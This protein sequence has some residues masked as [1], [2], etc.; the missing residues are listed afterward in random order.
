[1]LLRWLLIFSHLLGDVP[2]GLKN[3][4][5]NSGVNA[6]IQSIFYFKSMR[7]RVFE[8]KGQNNLVS[9]LVNFMQRMNTCATPCEESLEE[10]MLLVEEQGWDRNWQQS[11]EESRKFFRQKLTEQDKRFSTFYEETFAGK[12]VSSSRQLRKF[13]KYKLEGDKSMQNIRT[14]REVPKVLQ[15]Q[16]K[17]EFPFSELY[18]P[19]SMKIIPYDNPQA[20]VDFVLLF[21]VA[22]AGDMYYVYLKDDPFTPD[23]TWFE[24]DGIH[25]SIRTLEEVLQ[26]SKLYAEIVFYADKSQ[27]HTLFGK[28]FISRRM[29]QYI[30]VLMIVGGTGICVCVMF[31]VFSR[32]YDQKKVGPQDKSSKD[33]TEHIPML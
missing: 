32:R 23:G 26:A 21:V 7:R 31:I 12:Y 18:I 30:A 15:I 19:Q 24:V 16:L 27:L 22:K 9:G 6:F 25:V 29:N 8:L 28:P 10:F 4:G 14:I 2:T 11:F 5:Y 1:M 33:I 20:P 3:L 13:T 17:R